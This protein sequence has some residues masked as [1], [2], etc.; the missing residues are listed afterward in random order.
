MLAGQALQRHAGRVVTDPQEIRGLMTLNRLREIVRPTTC[1][2]S[3][4]LQGSMSPQSN[5]ERTDSPVLPVVTRSAAAQTSPSRTQVLE[6]LL[7]LAVQRLRLDRV[8]VAQDEELWIAN[9][10]RYLRGDLGSL[11]RREAKDC[12]KIA[13]QYEEGESGLL[14]YHTKGDEAAED[15]DTILKLVSRRL[16]ETT[17]SI[18][19]TQDLR[20]VTKGSDERINALDDISTDQ[21]SSQASSAMSES[22]R[23]TRRA[24]VVPRYK[25]R[26]QATSSQHT[27]FRS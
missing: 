5:P 11:F 4:D 18:T 10:K 23:T 20:E 13:P 17:S 2:A 14:D 3:A 9:L 15:R 8:R 21:G 7:D 12:R 24:R 19:I 25:A 26:P 16:S 27:R 1:D 6:A 22:V